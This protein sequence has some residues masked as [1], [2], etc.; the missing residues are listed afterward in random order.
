MHFW[1]T[2]VKKASFF[3]NEKYSLSHCLKNYIVQTAS[4]K[5]LNGH[6][7]GKLYNVEVFS[8]VFVKQTYNKHTFYINVTSAKEYWQENMK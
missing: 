4:S 6:Q 1:V 7:A 8:S 5:L 3:L 2:Q